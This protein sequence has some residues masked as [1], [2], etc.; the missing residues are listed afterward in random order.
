MKKINVY[1]LLSFLLLVSFACS[2]PGTKEV[3]VE[4][5]YKLYVP[6]SMQLTNELNDDA[7]L[8][9]MDTRKG[10]YVMV[11]E[12]TF[13]DLTQAYEEV[14]LQ[15]EFSLTLD[16]FMELVGDSESDAF[17]T[18]TDSS[19]MEATVINELNAM[20]L[21]NVRN[22]QGIDIYYKIAV[23]AGKQSF[24]QVVAWTSASRE[25]RNKEAI[26]S[27]VASFSEIE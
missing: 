13:E 10:L 18:T 21:T 16:A 24:Y 23:I 17:I 2:T 1:L 3:I 12:D 25:G 4:N 20:A 8:Q 7:S 11:I 22:L 15:D 14:G 19:R 9:Y 27:I 26:E 6:K 5:R